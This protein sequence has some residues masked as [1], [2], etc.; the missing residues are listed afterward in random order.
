MPPPVLPAVTA[1]A[2]I[3]IVDGEQTAVGF[4]TDKTGIGLTVIVMVL[5]V[6]VV[7]E[8]QEELDVRIHVISCPLVKVEVVKVVAVAAPTFTPFICH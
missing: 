3:S 5:E 4:V 7:G 8:A 6:A 2:V 1:A